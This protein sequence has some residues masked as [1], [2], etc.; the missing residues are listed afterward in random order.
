MKIPLMP[1]KPQRPPLELSSIKLYSTGSR[2]KVFTDRFYKSMN[3]NFGVQVTILNNTNT[4]QSAKIH[5]CV[6][7]SGDSQIIE[8]KANK[9]LNA[10]SE[11]S[12]DLYVKEENFEKLKN[13]KYK[14]KFWINDK[15]VMQKFFEVTYK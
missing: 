7:N 15:K 13:G 5:G 11:S 3:H 1:N 9:K 8:W 12:F 10:K 2:G 4:I 14:I 6:Y